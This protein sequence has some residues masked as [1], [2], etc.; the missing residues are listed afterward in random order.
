MKSKETKFWI[1]SGSEENWGIALKENK[2][3]V[4][5]KRRNFW[6]KLSRDDILGF[7]VTSPVSGIIGFGI[8]ENKKPEDYPLWPDEKRSG[9]VIYPLRW[10]FKLEYLCEKPWKDNKIFIK[11]L[12][13]P[14]Q[15]GLN[16]L[17]NKEQMVILIN[18]ANSTWETD[19]SVL[20][21][22][23]VKIVKKR[24]EKPISLHNKIREMIYEIG[25]MNNKYSEKEFSIDGKVDVIWRR[26]EQGHPSHAFEVQ[27]GGDIYHALVK[28]KHAFDM[29][30]ENIFL[31][32]EEK[33]FK[34]AKQLLSG[35]FHEIRDQIKIIQ[36]D[37]IEN[38]YKL[39]IEK[40]KLKKDFRF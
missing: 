33:D 10:T 37:R 27:I 39:D 5:S 31:V 14:Y 9:Q 15:G 21:P 13:I 26:I 17:T 18:R 28:L 22:G 20:M 23:G 35:A 40:Q 24:K 36:I 8:V 30:S 29:G 25:K 4:R 12:K 1:L 19:L 2:W 16:P 38:L 7:Y 6:N 32:A 3:G 11:D 34:K